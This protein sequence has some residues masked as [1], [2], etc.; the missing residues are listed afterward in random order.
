MPVLTPNTMLTI[1]PSV[2][3]ELKP[4]YIEERDLRERAKFL[5]QC[6][7][8]MWRRWSRE[9]VRSLR[10][11]HR[12]PGGKNISHP[13]KG[14]AVIIQD[15][16]KNRHRWKLGI[17]V[18][19]IEGRDGVIRAAKVKTAKGYLERAIQHLYPLELSCDEDKL[20]KLDPKEPD[21]VPREK[22]DAATAANHRNQQTAEN[23]EEEI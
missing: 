20:K 6:K 16:E 21:F 5:T 13:K 12:Q 4:H 1:N 7:E 19:L 10:E 8:I 18:G 14:D 2:L 15:E 9:Y 11:R 22:R 3:P 23:E 17:V